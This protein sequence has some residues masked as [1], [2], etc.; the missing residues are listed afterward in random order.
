M[1]Y[2]TILFSIILFLA[3]TFLTG[4]NLL[5]A[6]KTRGVN[7]QLGI[8]LPKTIKKLFIATIVVSGISAAITL[9][10]LLQQLLKS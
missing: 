1:E 4:Y 9:T 6:A 10:I 2:I 7:N 5:F 8:E 3:L